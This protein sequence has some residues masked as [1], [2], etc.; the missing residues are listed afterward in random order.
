MVYYTPVSDGWP[1]L[2]G[3]LKVAAFLL[4][5]YPDCGE[6]FLSELAGTLYR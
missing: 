4:T 2:A 5:K 6:D 1:S 3:C